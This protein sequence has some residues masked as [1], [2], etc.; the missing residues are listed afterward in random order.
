MAAA[1][2][3]IYAF[4]ELKKQ[5]KSVDELRFIFTS[6]AFIQEQ[7]DKQKREFYIP[8]LSREQS[9]Y[10]TEFEIKLRNEMTQRA[11]AQECADWIRKK[12][13]FKSNVSGENMTG[14]M[15]IESAE[16]SV[17]YNLGC[18]VRISPGILACHNNVGPVVYAFL[19][20]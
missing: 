18:I 1:C 7:A 5:L 8:R 20:Y 6:P 10:G 3:S 15:T 17:A 13:R 9:L 11:I 2:F 4:A 12:A 14:F 16:E 19:F